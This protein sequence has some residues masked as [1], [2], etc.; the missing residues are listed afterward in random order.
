MKRVTRVQSLQGYT[1]NYATNVVKKETF[2][3]RSLS[4]YIATSIKNV[5][6]KEGGK[7]HIQ[8]CW[9]TSKKIAKSRWRKNATALSIIYSM[10]YLFTFN[11]SFK[12]QASTENVDTP[13]WLK[14]WTL[15]YDWKRGHSIMTEN[16]DTPLWLKMWTLRYDCKRGHWIMTENVDTPLWLK[17]WTLSYDWKRGHSIMISVFKAHH[18]DSCK[19]R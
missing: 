15:H 8:P 19:G 18:H 13:L 2:L 1:I 4:I 6:G 3:P 7:K 11:H 9:K 12:T 5:R 16:V 10:T 14:T 17:T